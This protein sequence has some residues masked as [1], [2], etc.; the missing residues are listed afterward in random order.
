MISPRNNSHYSKNKMPSSKSI[1]LPD[2]PSKNRLPS[3]N[4]KLNNH[5]L[6]PKIPLASNGQNKVRKISIGKNKEISIGKNK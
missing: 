5:E 1:K 6:L 2:I 4:K 3:A